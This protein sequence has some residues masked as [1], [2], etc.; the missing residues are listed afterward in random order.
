MPNIKA[1]IEY[2][3]TDLHGFQKQR[4]LRTVQGELENTLGRLFQQSVVKVIGAGRTDAGVHAIGQVVNF[5]V[6]PKFPID[7]IWPAL[8]DLLPA[9][10]RVRSVEKVTDTF[11]ARYSAKA[12]TYLYV[13]LNRVAP[14]ALLAR[15]VWHLSR[16]L[17]LRAM[18]ATVG[19]LIGT[20]DFASFGVPERTGR[21]T[22]RQVFDFSIVRRKTAIF[23]TIRANAF[24]R[25]MAR[26]VVGTLVEIG[27]NKRR[28]EELAAILSAR[29]RHAAG[30][31]APPQGLYLT[32]VEY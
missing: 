27:Q 30:V 1:V 9:A 25:G 32:R 5:I 3:G 26:A 2:D 10:I 18:R 20:H 29:D 16:P 19:E 15:Y 7:K 17:D 6:P 21:S 24:L 23:F 14:S 12:R 28:P 4:S 22:V 11:H 8:N 13:V 31:S